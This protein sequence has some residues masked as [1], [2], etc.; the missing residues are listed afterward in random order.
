MPRQTLYKRPHPR[1]ETWPP[2]P[3]PPGMLSNEPAKEVF[4]AACASIAGAIT[5]LGFKYA[6][7]KL[8]CTR[9]RNG[10]TQAIAFQSSRYN[11]S[12][13]HVQLWMY[14]TV[15]SL[16][17]ETWRRRNL[18][19]ELASSHVAGGMVHLLGSKYAMVQWEL[20]DSRNRVATIQD[21]ITFIH[22]EVLPYFAQFDDVAALIAALAEHEVPAF[23]LVSSVEF[24]NC[25]GGRAQAQAVMDRFLRDREDLAAEIAS[26]QLNASESTLLIPR[27]YAQQ[28]VF[29]RHRYGLT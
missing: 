28:V 3:L 20:A 4:Q 19:E 18:P 27:N 6:K 25:F 7:S 23:D 26:E 9:E 10:F 2:D 15:A 14:A 24:A 11:V 16:E 22:D 1:L 21:A 17:L 29:L 13:Q 12:G 8:R 5:P